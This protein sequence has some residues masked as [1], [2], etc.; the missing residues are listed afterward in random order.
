MVARLLKVAAA[1]V[2]HMLKLLIT[3]LVKELNSQLLLG[4]VPLILMVGIV[5]LNRQREVFLSRL[6]EVCQVQMVE[7]VVQ[8]QAVLGMSEVLGAAEVVCSQRPITLVVAVAAL[9][10]PQL[11]AEMDLIL[12]AQQQ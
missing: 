8:Q 5:L 6:L 3:P 7:P 12:Q 9:L 10:R 2:V 4:E 1:V 11:M